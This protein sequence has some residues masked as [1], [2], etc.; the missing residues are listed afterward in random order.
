MIPRLP[1]LTIDELTSRLGSAARA[2]A[3]VRWLYG[4][5]PLP[6]ALP[7]AV[8]G[9]AAA[10]WRTLRA[11]TPWNPPLVRERQASADGTT[12]YALAFGAT[13]V[14]AVRIPSP[15][16]STVCVSSQSGCTRRCVFCA[17]RTL[18]FG[19]HLRADEM[20]LQVMLAAAEAPPEAPV[21]NVVFMGMGEPMD[22]LGEVLRAVR[23]LTQSP[24]PLL[25]ARSITVSTSGVLPGMRRFLRESPAS[26]ALSLHATTDDV[27]ARLVPHGRIW[28][29]AALMALLREDAARHP[30]RECF[31]EYVLC[32]GVNDADA[33]ADRL[34]RLLDGIGARVN[35]IPYNAFPGSDLAPPPSA[36][37]L[38]FQARLAAAG[39]RAFIRWPRGRAIAAACGQ[40]A[41]ATATA[42]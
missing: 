7:A 5:A 22:N 13:L 29:I 36:R 6:Q 40:L 23:V 10:A 19:R 15:R 8:P 41:L 17:T 14:E 38:A 30:R 39:R 12:K 1:A 25:R 11:A 28:P 37:V 16:R 42:E 33:D 35:L 9:V 4:T 26:L 20:V 32:A 27:R 18:G 2:R 21:R 34:L 3:V 24:A 31:V